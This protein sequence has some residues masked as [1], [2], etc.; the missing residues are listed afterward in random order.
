MV[1]IADAPLLDSTREPHSQS[2]YEKNIL[3]CRV[4]PDKALETVGSFQEEGGEL[5]HL[6]ERLLGNPIEI[7]AAILRRVEDATPDRGSVLETPQLIVVA[8][9]M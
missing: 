9:D 5:F 1:V 4:A 3:S 2:L 7:T 6:L 8:A